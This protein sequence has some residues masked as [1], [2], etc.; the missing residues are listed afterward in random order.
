M[1][2]PNMKRTTANQ[3]GFMLLEALIG[4]LV[5]ALGILAIVGMQATSIA[6]ASDA[7]YRTEASFLAEELIGRISV[8]RTNIAAYATPPQDWLT[9]VAGILPAGTG[10]VAV[11]AADPNTG[12]PSVTVSVLW[13]PPGQPQHSYSAVAQITGGCAVSENC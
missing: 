11:A 2:R 10:T 13:T 8:D 4:V 3:Q 6:N 9:H 7:K 1:L 12:Q 5:F